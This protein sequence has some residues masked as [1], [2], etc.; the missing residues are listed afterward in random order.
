MRNDARPMG[1][2]N[3]PLSPVDA[4]ESI[5]H[6]RPPKAHKEPERARETEKPLKD[7]PR[8]PSERREG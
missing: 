3:E 7:P 8:P 6:G 2:A 5:K 4:R 1:H